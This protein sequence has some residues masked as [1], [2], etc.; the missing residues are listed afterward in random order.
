L[1]IV[2]TSVPEKVREQLG[3]ESGEGVFVGHVEPKAPADRAGIRNGDVI[4]KW[5]DKTA[6]NPALLSRTI[7]ATKI[8]STATVRLV[9]ADSHDAGAKPTRSELEVTVQVERHP[10]FARPVNARQ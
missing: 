1:G 6:T 10:D 3:L 4:L 5:N 8:G 9:R 7:A 2:P